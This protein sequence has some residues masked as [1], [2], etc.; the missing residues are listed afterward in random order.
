MIVRERVRVTGRDSKIE[1]MSKSKCRCQ[2]R[3]DLKLI[4]DNGG[5]GHSSEIWSSGCVGQYVTSRNAHKMSSL[6]EYRYG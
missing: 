1:S 5:T 6:A 2:Y 4:D 3:S